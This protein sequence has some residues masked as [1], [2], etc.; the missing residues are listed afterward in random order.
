M[1]KKARL[2]EESLRMQFDMAKLDYKF[3]EN[4]DQENLIYNKDVLADEYLHFF[5]KQPAKKSLTSSLLPKA[6]QKSESNNEFHNNQS[7]LIDAK[8]QN[9]FVSGLLEYDF[10]CS[11]HFKR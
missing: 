9:Y 6:V 8:F 5:A 4:K 11:V 10:E 7:S 3:E 2:L 1:R